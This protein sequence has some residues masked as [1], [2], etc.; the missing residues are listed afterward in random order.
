LSAVETSLP[1]P[2]AINCDITGAYEGTGFCDPSGSAYPNKVTELNTINLLPMTSENNN[3]GDGNWILNNITHVSGFNEIEHCTL[4]VLETKLS[5]LIDEGPVYN[6][7]TVYRNDVNPTNS[8]NVILQYT[9]NEDCT[10]FDKLVHIVG[11][12]MM[13][14]GTVQPSQICKIKAT[15]TSSASDSTSISSGGAFFSMK[16]S[17]LFVLANT[18]IAVTVSYV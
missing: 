14:D 11:G 18:I 9:S 1:P 10:S 13:T 5:A 6:C 15:E 12:S 4:N 16:S 17:L 8:S 7:F 2:P 3:K